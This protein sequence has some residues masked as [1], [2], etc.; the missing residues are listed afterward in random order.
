MAPLFLSPFPRLDPSSAS[1]QRWAVDCDGRDVSLQDLAE[2]CDANSSLTFL[3]DVSVDADALEAL[4]SPGSP[5]LVVSVTCSATAFILT[6][7]T[8]LTRSGDRFVARGE[9]RLDAHEVTAQL[10]LA[11]TI[12]APVADQPWLRDRIV[13]EAKTEK[14]SLEPSQ[15]GFPVSV[16]SF[17][18]ES[19][20]AA[21]WRF[22]L[23]A[24]GLE[25]GF[26]SSMRLYVNEDYP[27]AIDLLDGTAPRISMALLEADIARQL[28]AAAH[29]LSRDLAESGSDASLSGDVD[30][31]AEE[32]PES[33]AAAAARIAARFFQR[34]L[35]EVCGIYRD[36]PEYFEYLLMSVTHLL[37]GDA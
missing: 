2:H 37:E 31:V 16:V 4:E 26:R 10:D 34:S 6:H 19:W 17:R 36:E 20:Q 23:Y 5:V 12:V 9:L 32:N 3:I 1:W 35:R 22:D 13:A 33:I 24:A 15:P 21:P 8:P 18:N 30:A 11:A 27:Q 7:R 25:D 14:V 28:I 29:R